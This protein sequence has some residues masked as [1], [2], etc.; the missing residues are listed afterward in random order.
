MTKEIER[1]GLP[2]AMVSALPLIPQSLGV[3][4]I[5]LGKAIV[6]PL[7]DPVLPPEEE[8]AYRRRIVEAALTALETPVERPTIFAAEGV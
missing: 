6:H 4:R 1:V 5:V 3:S 7:G 8:L 2:T